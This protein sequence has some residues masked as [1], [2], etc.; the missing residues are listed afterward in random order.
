MVKSSTS[1]DLKVP[2]PTC[3]VKKEKSTP[4]LL[5]KQKSLNES[6]KQ[7]TEKLT[8]LEIEYKN[9]LGIYNLYYEDDKLKDEYYDRTDGELIKYFKSGI[10]KRWASADIVLRKNKEVKI[11]DSLRMSVKWD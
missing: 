3:N 4:A 1:T 8:K 9:A 11:L 7:S 6:I 2:S 5:K 10:M